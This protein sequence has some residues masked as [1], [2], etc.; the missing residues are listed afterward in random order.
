M[1]EIKLSRAGR[2]VFRGVVVSDKMNKTRVVSVERTTRHRGYAKILKKNEK[3]YAHDEAN[4]SRAGDTVELMS[5][6]PLSSLKR[7][8]ISRI[9][10]KA[11]N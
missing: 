2:K 9:V 11:R 3:F 10:E 5:T 1:N 4:E 8:R 6:R 7:W